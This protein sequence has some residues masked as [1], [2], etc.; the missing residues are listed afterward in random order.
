MTDTPDRIRLWTIATDQPPSVVRSLWQLLDAAERTR[1][2]RDP[3]RRDRFTVVRGAVRLLTAAHLGIEPTALVWRRGPYGKPAPVGGDGLELSWS[4]SGTLAVL[5]VA[6]GRP[7]GA[8]VEELAGPRVALRIARRHFPPGDLAEVADAPTAGEGAERFTELWCRR[9]AC[10]K[11]HGAR[12][13]EG[14]GLALAGP[15]PL[16][17]DAPGPLGRGPLHLCDVP[18]AATHRAAV[19]A[20]GERPFTVA[21][22]PWMPLAPLVGNGS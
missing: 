2:A 4:G 22:E 6:E 11:A 15:S 5:A 12:L 17:L 8:D 16:R 19:A 7:I 13:A 9:E 20:C 3:L 1:A 14:L 21:A 10:V 18:V